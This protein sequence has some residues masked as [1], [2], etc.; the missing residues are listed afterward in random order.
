MSKLT[1]WF[2]STSQSPVR[3]GWYD[4][5]ECS[6]RHYFKGGLWY[7]KKKSLDDDVPMLINK[8][9][10]RGLARPSLKSLLAEFD[11]SVPR[12]QDEQAWLDM[13][14]VGR[15]FGSPDYERLMRE[16]FEIAIKAS[17][18]EVAK[19]KMKPYKFGNSP[20]R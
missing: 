4:C 18:E 15:E 2:N 6:A 3:E 16:D 10:W 7:R 13:A 1:P 11:P 14:P 20:K 17:M 12:S 9:H 19:E 8:M 5:K